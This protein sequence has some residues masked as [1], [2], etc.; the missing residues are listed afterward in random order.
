MAIPVIEALRKPGLRLGLAQSSRVRWAA[1]AGALVVGVAFALDVN[2]PMENLWAVIAAFAGAGTIW[3]SAERPICGLACCVT[4]SF[5]AGAGNASSAG[6]ELIII[7]VVYQATLAGDIGW[8]VCALVSLAALGVNNFVLGSL[9]GDPLWDSTLLYPFVLTALGVGLGSQGRRLHDALVE[10][11]RLQE[12]DRERVRSDERSAIARDL[13]DVAAHHLPALVVRNKLARMKGGEKV[14]DD[15]AAFSATTA[16]EALDALRQVVGVL[17]PNE[18][19]SV[20]DTQE[21]TGGGRRPQP[22]LADLPAILRHGSA[23]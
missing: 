18:R 20:G 5:A 6:L 21:V 7:V 19:S 12:L 15:A 23:G 4:L 10:V 13:H 8:R 17:A 3:Y 1:T 11:V 9:S 2:R 14:L 22:T 16:S